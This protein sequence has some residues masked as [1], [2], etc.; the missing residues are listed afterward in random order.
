MTIT[1]FE[2]KPWGERQWEQSL[3]LLKEQWK[4][5]QR[6]AGNATKIHDENARATIKGLVRHAPEV[7]ED[8]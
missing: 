8:Q 7:S 5:K 1:G 6:T 3:A 2:Y 4:L